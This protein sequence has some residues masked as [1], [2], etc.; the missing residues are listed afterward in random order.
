MSHQITR[1]PEQEGAGNL[2]AMLN[3]PTNR[4][5][6]DQSK[7][8]DQALNR[9]CE[10]CRTSKVRCLANPD[11]DSN[12]CQRCAKA[13]RTCVFAAP[14]KRRQRKRTDVRVAELEKEIKKMQSLITGSNQ[15]PSGASDHES[16]D[17]ESDERNI[18]AEETSP[19]GSQRHGSTTT[20][21]STFTHH[22][23]SAG[24]PPQK[25]PTVAPGNNCGPKDLL[26]PVDDI[27]DRG[28]ITQE[29][30]E[31]LL[32][33]WRNELVAASPG[34]YIA[35]DWTAAQLREK[36]PSL[37][38]A[39]MAAAAH[40]KG[41]A[42]SDVLH[43]EAVYLY[44]R[45]AFINGEKSVQTIQAL[46]VTVAFYSPPKTPGQLQIY[47]WVN[48]AASMA[49]ELGLASKPRTHEQLPK[50]AIRS[51]QKISSPEEL[52]EHC[53][54]VLYF[55]MEECL[56]MLEKSPLQAD[57]R[58]LAWLKLQRI[59]DEANTA[60]GF[61]DASTSFSL[62][63]LRMQM[64]LRIFERR[65]H[66]WKKSVPKEVLTLTLTMEYHQNMLS[67]WEFGMDGG[68]YDVTEFRNRHLTLPALDD[69]SVQPESL[70][71]RSPL[72]IN[73]TTKCIIEAHA[74]L[75]CFVEIPNDTLQKAPNLI[76]VRA[77]YALVVLM[78]ADYAVGTDPEM[79]EIL[80]SQSLKVD[81]YLQ[82]VVR[83]TSEAIGPQKCRMPSHWTFILETKLICW[84]EEYLEWR[85]EERHLKRRKA[86]DASA[87]NTSGAR[88]PVHFG[89]GRG[90]K[91][92]QETAPPTQSVSAL[93]RHLSQ[94]PQPPPQ[95][96]S[97]L[98]IANLY[99]WAPGGLPQAANPPMGEQ[100]TFSP[101]AMGD[102]SAA[103]QNGDLYLW[104]DINDNFG[105]WIPQGGSL[106]TDTGFGPLNGQGY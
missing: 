48:M 65:M 71:S 62:S 87:T 20:A 55:W 103:F 40:S 74:I 6:S 47:Q 28:V 49:L 25:S 98:N 80:D 7:K 57:Q 94:P 35:K 1:S 63:E 69:D 10:A 26:G 66:D 99:A 42:L 67:M 100:S 41:S 105:G 31:E 59:A 68:R 64:I 58:T 33:I 30:A 92:Q 106:Y 85:R 29:L 19:L 89:D 81:H 4:P 16:M 45:T 23:P 95:P 27:I 12:Q 51:L 97:N 91:P 22:W 9:A 53:R 37:F 52:L 3:H 78:K 60:F 24:A 21:T 72:Q 17:E 14:V 70:L 54:T 86:R 83:K 90:R 11:P 18:G 13:G 76:F 61:D 88:S 8:P 102:F 75:E 77:I 32:S 44:A 46:L 84:R 5:D 73:A 2:L 36:K 96:G 104:N 93:E 79:G 39:V 34:I 82:T 38:Y 101:P 50:R 56:N 15:S 43:E